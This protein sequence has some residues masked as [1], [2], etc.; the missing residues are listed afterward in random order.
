MEQSPTP[1]KILLIED[2]QFLAELVIERFSRTGL[3]VDLAVDGEE[4]LAKIE[5]DRPAL[6]LLDLVLPGIDGYEVLRQLKANKNLAHIPVLI[7]SNL[8]QEDEIKRG[9]ELGALGFLVKA[10]FDLDEI[11]EKVQQILKRSSSI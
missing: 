4:G 9:L 5:K 6:I 2:D 11:V 1:Q 7:L 3:D 8:G 10:N